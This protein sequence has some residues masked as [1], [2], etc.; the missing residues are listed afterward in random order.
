MK[1]LNEES[2]IKNLKL[3]EQIE[4]G[5]EDIK[6]GKFIVADTNMDAEKIDDLLMC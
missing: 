2:L 3:I 4:M 5:E 1:Q 6:K